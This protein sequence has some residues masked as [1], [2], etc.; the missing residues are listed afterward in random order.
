MKKRSYSIIALALLSFSPIPSKADVWWEWYF[1]GEAGYFL[2]DG[3]FADAATSHTFTIKEVAVTASAYG[4]SRGTV[5]QGKYEISQPDLG[6]MWNGTHAIQFFRSS[7]NFTNGASVFSG[8]QPSVFLGFQPNGG[9]VATNSEVRHADEII[10][11][12]SAL[13][14]LIPIQPDLIA[15]PDALI[16]TSSAPSAQRG[17]DLYND[18]TQKVIV[19]AKDRRTSKYYCSVN[20][21]ADVPESFLIRG[22]R[23][24][25]ILDVKYD[26]WDGSKWRNVTAAMSGS[27]FVTPRYLPGDHAQIKVRVKPDTRGKRRTRNVRC[28]V[29]STVDATSTDF[30]NA[31]VKVKP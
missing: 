2:T 24:N 18:A 20:T 25:R 23:G 1:A 22:T 7:G 21:D 12:V 27:G 6:F 16:G 3:S 28:L 5:S 29:T 19:R 8:E 13:L 4:F 15:R 14:I 30:V 9:G 10:P 17:N 11:Y 26:H 31:T